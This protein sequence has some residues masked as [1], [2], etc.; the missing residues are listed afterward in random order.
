[1]WGFFMGLLLQSSFLCFQLFL[2]CLCVWSPSQLHG[3]ACDLNGLVSCP[4]SS[5]Y[6]CLF[7]SCLCHGLDALSSSHK[8]HR[9]FYWA[10]DLLYLSL[11][12]VVVSPLLN[13]GHYMLC[14]FPPAKSN[15]G[16]FKFQLIRWLV[17]HPS[18]S[19]VP[20]FP[21]SLND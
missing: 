19:L 16:A 20:A 3:L 2:I 5:T 14:P 11:F 12:L 7:A 4:L 18:L 6:L 10:C 21:L 8:F 15:F 9:L 13:F 1:M 17:S